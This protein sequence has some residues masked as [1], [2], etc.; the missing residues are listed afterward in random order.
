MS[1]TKPISAD[2][3]S[4][5]EPSGEFSSNLGRAIFQQKIESI[6]LSTKNATGADGV[7]VSLR[8]GSAYVC[9]ASIGDAPEI[10]VS[11]EPGQGI[12]GR[13]ITEAKAVVEQEID[14]PIKSV[15]AV[16]IMRE[17]KAYGF[18]AGFA[19]RPNAFSSEA[20]ED[21]ERMAEVIHSQVEPIIPITLNAEIKDAADDELLAQLGIVPEA[22]SNGNFADDDD[23]FLAELVR[24][25]LGEAPSSKAIVA[26]Q[27]EEKTSVEPEEKQPTVQA[28]PARTTEEVLMQVVE[29]KPA[30]PP[31]PPSGMASAPASARAAPADEPNT[32]V[33]A[34]AERKNEV[35]G[36]SIWLSIAPDSGAV[37]PASTPEEEVTTLGEAWTWRRIAP[38]AVILLIVI[39]SSWYFL[40]RQRT[41]N[42]EPQKM[43]AT[44]APTSMP[45]TTTPPASSAANTSAAPQQNKPAE[46]T[47]TSEKQPV[48]H[49]REPLLVATNGGPSRANSAVE[50]APPSLNGVPVKIS[51]PVLPTGNSD[52]VFGG[53]R[54]TGAVPPKLIQRVEPSY[55]AMARSMH[56]TG[57]VRLEV[58]VASDGKVKAVRKLEGNEMLAN[59]AIQAVR[60]WRYE[61]AKQDGTYVESIVEVI[62]NF[63]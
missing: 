49:E 33:M 26:H 50:D 3:G 59:A 8:E 7:A 10:G 52:V 6:L 38:I 23:S 41:S 22:K 47:T 2:F 27:S 37:K 51:A 1:T 54:S 14:G 63:R 12:C 60:R 48:I 5:D 53:R 16:P 9:R 40:R 42:P 30:K 43:A 31:K 46:K 35:R 20:I 17:G 19:L 57:K 34:N 11:V 45:E 36:K 18:V 61:A 25:V 4:T 28:F 32:A 39:A 55:P 13:C 24:D 44:T 58:T 29:H 62:F 21:F 15:A 56:A